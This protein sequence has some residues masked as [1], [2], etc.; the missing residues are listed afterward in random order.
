MRTDV[1]VVGSLHLDIVVEG[2]AL[3]R[4]DET[5]RGKSWHMVCGG[6]GGNQACWSAKCG[7][8][9]A[10][11][12]RIGEDDF[13]HRLLANLKNHGVNTKAVSTSTSA[14]SGMSVALVDQQGDYGAV[15]VSGSNFELTP[16]Q[17]LQEMAQFSDVKLLLLQNELHE[18]VN[19]AAAQK[20]KSMGATVLLNA[21][22]A[23]AFSSEFIG[24]IDILV[25]NRVEAEMLGCAT[26]KTQSDAIQAITHLHNYA[27]QVIIT[28]GG[29]GL[30]VSAQD[31]VET[32]DAMD[33]KVTSTHGAGDCFI[34]QLS[35]ALAKGE[36]IFSAC[37]RANTIAAAFVSKPSGHN[38]A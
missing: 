11:I 17:V 36:D 33:V 20:A 22:P 34:G 38:A 19:L 16:Q 32:I 2:A 35:A 4:L 12:A 27:P 10:M 8:A 6:K 1:L 28:L 14:G 3:P 15:I 18:D 31:R 26:P 9:T 24:L 29:D 21:A 13:G 23:R 7:A 5:A 37:S 30:V 25:V